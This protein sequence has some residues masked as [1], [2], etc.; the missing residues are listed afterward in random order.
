MQSDAKEFIIGTRSALRKRCKM[1]GPEKRFYPL[2]KKLI[3]ENMKSTT[4]M[5]IYHILKDGEG[6]EIQLDSKTIAKARRC[7]DRMIALGG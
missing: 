6:T 7:I 5:D 1:L 4:L 2:A 3:C